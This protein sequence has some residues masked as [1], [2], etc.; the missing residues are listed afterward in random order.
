MHNFRRSVIPKFSDRYVVLQYKI[1]E[2]VR[3]IVRDVGGEGV[4]GQVYDAVY[5][6]P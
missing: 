4:A 6:C 1:A 2:I 5:Y 3:H